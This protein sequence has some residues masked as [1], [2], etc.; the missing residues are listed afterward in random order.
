M[1]K[2]IKK[3]SFVFFV[4]VDQFLLYSLLFVGN[5]SDLLVHLLFVFLF[6]SSTLLA[7]SHCIFFCLSLLPKPNTFPLFRSL[8][9]IWS[10]LSICRFRSN[11]YILNGVSNWASKFYR[12]NFNVT[13]A[14]WEYKWKWKWRQ[15]GERENQRG[16]EGGEGIHLVYGIQVCN[17]FIA[18]CA[19][20]LKAAHLI[21]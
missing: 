9:F 10:L 1:L 2:E 19:K 14:K 21:L 6:A 3:C 8:L 11:P 4:V 15:G 7:L 13:W 17:I 5:L 18:H 20:A 16:R 12:L